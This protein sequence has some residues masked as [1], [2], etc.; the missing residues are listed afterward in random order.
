MSL[1]IRINNGNLIMSGGSTE[2]ILFKM[3]SDK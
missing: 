1:N 2:K 3:S